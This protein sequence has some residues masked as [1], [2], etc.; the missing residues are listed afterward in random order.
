MNQDAEK[1]PRAICGSKECNKEK[2]VP[3]TKESRKRAFNL[4]SKIL[5]ELYEPKA[6][7]LSAELGDVLN[8]IKHFNPEFRMK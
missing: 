8:H 6:Q 7:Q 2:I 3:M 4:L 1:T 5:S